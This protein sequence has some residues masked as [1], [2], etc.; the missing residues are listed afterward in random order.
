VDEQSR[1]RYRSAVAETALVV[2]VPEMEPLVAAWRDQSTADGASVMPPH[3]TL[4][5]PFADD[6]EVNGLLTDVEDALAPFAPFAPFEATFTRIAR[7]P[8]VLYLEPAEPRPFMALVEA[9]AAAFPRYPPYGGA[10]DSI[11]PH[12]TVAHGEDVDFAPIEAALR[13][14]LPV[15]VRVEHVWLMAHGPDGWQRRAAF[16][17]SRLGRGVGG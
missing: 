8:D 15:T 9:L 5:Y 10:H 17:L 1:F 4:L 2:V 16:P 11:V 3:V 7:W 14:T 12:V 6:A 13:P